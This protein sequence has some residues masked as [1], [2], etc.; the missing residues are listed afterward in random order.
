MMDGPLLP[1]GVRVVD[2]VQPPAEA[3]VEPAAD[4]APGPAADEVA[5]EQEQVDVMYARLD[6]LRARTARDLADV[7]RAGPSGTHQNR[8]ERDSF[9]TL[10][11]HRLA[12]LE[13]V[14][15]RLA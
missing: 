6:Q 4:H 15:D 7:R 5:R 10:H 9:A 3:S 13:A 11:E 12:Q 8:S 2:P 14:E 1:E